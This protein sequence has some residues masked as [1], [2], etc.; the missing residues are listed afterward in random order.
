MSLVTR[1]P[2]E[3]AHL[4]VARRPQSRGNGARLDLYDDEG[5][6]GAFVEATPTELTNAGLIRLDDNDG[7]E[8]L[9]V[10]HPGRAVRARV[11]RAGS[12]LGFVSRLGRVRANIEIHGPGRK[13]EGAPMAVLRPIEDGSAWTGAGATIRW[14]RLSAPT[15]GGYGEARYTVDLE[16]TVDAELRPL[17]LAATVLVDRSLV[18]SVS[19]MA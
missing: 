11:D 2:R 13:P 10:L 4:V 6:L 19:P 5:A 1:S 3:L 9:S 17:V 12:P 16:P 18:Q 14:W 15:A 7:T 8:L